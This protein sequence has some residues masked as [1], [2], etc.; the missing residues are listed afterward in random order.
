LKITK[1]KKKMQ[2]LPSKS[3]FNVHQLK[4]YCY[5]DSSWRRTNNDWFYIHYLW[6]KD[7]FFKIYLIKHLKLFFS[8]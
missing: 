7:D 4:S 6:K 1:G 8:L 5:M 2:Q 3:Y